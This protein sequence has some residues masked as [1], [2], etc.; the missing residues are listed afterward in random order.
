[1]GDL[2][3]DPAT[4]DFYAAEAPVYVA[5][6]FDGRSRHLDDFLVRLT[7]GASILELGCGGGRDSEAMIA[8]GFRVD[9]TDGVPAIAVQAE[10]RLKRPVRVM[11]FDQIDAIEH[12]DAVWA[13]ASL[14]HIPREALPGVLAAIWRAL[15]PGVWHFANFKGGG[16]EGRDSMGR[17]FSYLSRDQ[18]LAAYAGAGAWH[19]AAAWDYQGGG[20]DCRQGP[21]VAIT[22]QKPA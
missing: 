11:R 18:M 10:E 21:W 16:T 19:V 13:H 22:V 2:P 20:Y 15:K 12:Y 6:G 14:L 17:Y 5:S 4:L 1:M 3:F 9:P 7:P 8:A